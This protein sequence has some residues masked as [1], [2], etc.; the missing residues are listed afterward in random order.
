MKSKRTKALDISLKVKEI[1]WERDN[2]CCIL[3]GNPQAMPNAHYVPRSSG[4]L[5]IKENVVTLC[6]KHHDDY[7]KTT[8]RQT[9]MFYIAVYLDNKYP[10]FKHND[11][12]YK[13]GGER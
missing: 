4:G 8:D 9:L 6:Q 3:C 1:V 2:K 7:D 13:K 10:N 5:G 12:F 11:R